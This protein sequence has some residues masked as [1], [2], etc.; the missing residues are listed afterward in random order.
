MPT[1]LTSKINRFDEAARR[2]RLLSPDAIQ[3]TKAVRHPVLAY[4]FVF[5]IVSNYA[6]KKYNCYQQIWTPGGWANL[7]TIN[8]ICYVVEDSGN[9]WPAGVLLK[10]LAPAN[11]N[12]EIP[13]DVISYS[14][15]K[16]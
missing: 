7:S 4:S 2:E 12:G 5:K 10:A 1:A 16:D 8:H 3:P 9:T 13:A 15:A 6:S 11:S 14:H